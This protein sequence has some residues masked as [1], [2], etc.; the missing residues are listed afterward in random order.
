[1]FKPTVRTVLLSLS[2]F[3][4]AAVTFA[5]K[6]LAFGPGD[7]EPT[8][9]DV[10]LAGR[11]AVESFGGELVVVAIDTAGPGERPDGS[12][13]HMARFT[14]AE[15][16]SPALFFRGQALVTFERDTLRVVP[17]DGSDVLVFSVD[18]LTAGE[19]QERRFAH[20]IELHYASDQDFGSVERAIA[21]ARREAKRQDLRPMIAGIEQEHQDEGGGGGGCKS[22]CS[23]TCAGGGGTCSVTCH[24]SK[25]AECECEGE[26]NLASCS[27][28]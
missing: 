8:R 16:I 24:P 4:F 5:E 11:V 23:T 19:D 13:D 2:L 28:N 7:T 10:S 6:P 20:G 15:A 12:T 26:E 27:C 22:K 18:A 9:V 17:L 1:M 25:C 3:S 14:A 21:D